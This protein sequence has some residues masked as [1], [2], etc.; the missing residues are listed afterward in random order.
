MIWEDP[1]QAP[2]MLS[3]TSTVQEAPQLCPFQESWQQTAVRQQWAARLPHDV[4]YS[5]GAHAGRARGSQAVL[6]LFTSNVQHLFCPL[7]YS[8]R[9]FPISCPT[10][11]PDMSS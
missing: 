2:A 4:R 8:A 5:L 9:S 11:E 3:W 10:F 1:P 7:G 6:A